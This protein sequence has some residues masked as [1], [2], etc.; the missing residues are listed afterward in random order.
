MVVATCGRSDAAVVGLVE[1]T[2]YHAAAIAADPEPAARYQTVELRPTH[3]SLGIGMLSTLP[4]IGDPQ[5]VR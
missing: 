1:L 5:P 2:P 4:P 3:G